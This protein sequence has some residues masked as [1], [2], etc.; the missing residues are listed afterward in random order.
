MKI[1]TSWDD[2]YSYDLRVAKLLIKYNLPGTFYIIIDR[3][4]TEGYLDWEQIKWLDSNK[5]EIG[6]HTM[7]HPQDLKKLYDDELK[8]EIQTS[9]EF[10]ETVLGHKIVSFCY[11]RGRYD[12]RVIRQV[13]S[14][15]YLEARTTVVGKIEEPVD[16]MKIDT[17]VH[18]FKRQEYKN[19]TWSHFGQL[20]FQDAKELE[21]SVFHLW[22]HSWE[23]ERDNQW[24]NLENFFKYIKKN[25]N[26]NTN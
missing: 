1:K 23:V 25:E 19:L 26:I 3:V 2:G 22:G 15:G 18:V 8:Y 6:S 9:K 10:L 12:E 13:V 16:K 17:S 11:P 5:F 24:E 7:S 14:A 21:G 20:M 4:G